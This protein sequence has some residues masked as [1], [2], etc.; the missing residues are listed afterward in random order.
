MMMEE[1]GI[2]ADEQAIGFDNSGTGSALILGTNKIDML[3]RRDL[4]A[5]SGLYVEFR[6]TTSFT[7]GS[8]TP[9]LQFGIVTGDAADLSG[10]S[11]I[12]SLCGGLVPALGIGAEFVSTPVLVSSQLTAGLSVYMPMP[13]SSLLVSALANYTGGVRNSIQRYLGVGFFQPSWAL[14]Y[15]ATGSMSARLVM[16]PTKVHFGPDAL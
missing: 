1:L 11:T 5:V 2:F 10:N 15:F 6:V 9:T 8:G 14:N 16:N 12:L 3:Q 7:V 4:D 13:R